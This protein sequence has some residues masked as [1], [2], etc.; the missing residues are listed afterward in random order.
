[1]PLLVKENNSESPSRS[2]NDS[3]AELVN[4]S[5]CPEDSSDSPAKSVNGSL[6]QQKTVH[7]L[8]RAEVTNGSLLHEDSSFRLKIPQQSQ[9]MEISFIIRQFAHFLSQQSQQMTVSFIRRQFAHFLS[10]QSQ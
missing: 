9:Q 1:M 5:L 10:Q 3:P 7:L 4:G 8:F 2:T 6:F